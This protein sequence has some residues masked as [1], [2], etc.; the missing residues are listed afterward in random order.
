MVWRSTKEEL[1]PMCTVST[2]KHGGRSVKCWGYFSSIGVGNLVF[3]DEN[4]TGELYRDILQK[5]S[6]VSVCEQSEYG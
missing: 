2:V 6:S 4:M 3:I 1:D 5:K